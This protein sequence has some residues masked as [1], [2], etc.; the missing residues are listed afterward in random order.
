MT[1]LEEVARAIHA[2]LG[3]DPRKLE[4]RVIMLA[5][6]NVARA[7]IQA[8]R[9]PS[10]MMSLSGNEVLNSA[11]ETRAPDADDVFRAMID[12]VLSEGK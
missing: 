7:A 8:M 9:G 4:H 1:K 11:T 12:Q 2:A 10:T 5:Y 6:R 3:K